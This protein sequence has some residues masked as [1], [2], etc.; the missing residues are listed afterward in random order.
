MRSGMLCQRGD[1]L[2]PDWRGRGSAL[3]GWRE[4]AGGRAEARDRG[5]ARS[6]CRLPPLVGPR[7]ADARI[8]NHPPRLPS[9]APAPAPAPF[10]SVRSGAM[11]RSFSSGTRL[12]VTLCPPKLPAAGAWRPAIPAS[13]RDLPLHAANQRPESSRVS[14]HCISDRRFDMPESRSTDPLVWIDCEM[15]GLDTSTDTIMSLAC[16]VTDHELNLLDETGYEAVIGHGQSQMDAMGDWCRQHHGD[17]GLTQ[18]CLDSTTTAEDAALELL[19]Y[20]QRFVPERRRAL[21][22]GN[23]VHADKAF[24]SLEPWSKVVR[25]LHH[26][27]LD[28]SAIKEAARRWAP[29]EVLKKSPQKAGRHEAKAD[30]LE[31]IAEAKYYRDVFFAAK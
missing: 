22:A 2:S 17:S 28:V 3:D 16:F 4:R 25:H 30:I 18:A 19:R 24:L 14:P 27:I 8:T 6:F 12:H 1:L 15:T 10:I 11:S 7:L 9:H 13:A 23:T 31:S 29:E 20:V 21:L 26:R 5:R